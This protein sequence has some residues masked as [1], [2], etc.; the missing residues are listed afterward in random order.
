MARAWTRQVE[1]EREGGKGREKHA[2][3]SSVLSEAVKKR[4]KEEKVE[5]GGRAGGLR[6]ANA[7]CNS[8]MRLPTSTRRK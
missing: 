5:E 7:S 4:K 2:E 6:C 8:T 3:G 1:G